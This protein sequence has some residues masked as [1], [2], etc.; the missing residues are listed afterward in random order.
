MSDDSD[1]LR[2]HAHLF[3]V[4]VAFLEH[5]IAVQHRLFVLDLRQIWQIVEVLPFVEE[6]VSG[7]G[8]DVGLLG[9]F[10][11][12]RV[13]EAVP[14]FAVGVCGVS[15]VVTAVEHSGMRL[16]EENNFKITQNPLKPSTTH[17]NCIQLVF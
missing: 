8:V 7:A 2:Q 13:V 1:S 11:A 16:A 4:V 6:Q 14:R 17:H 5:F 15:D 3:Q 9:D 10:A 12:R